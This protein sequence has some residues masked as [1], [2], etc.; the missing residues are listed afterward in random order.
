MVEYLLGHSSFEDMLAIVRTGLSDEHRLQNALKVLNI[1]GQLDQ[2]QITAKTDELDAARRMATSSYYRARLT[3]S[4][5]ELSALSNRLV[6]MQRFADP[7][8]AFLAYRAENAGSLPEPQTWRPGAAVPSFAG[9]Q[10][11]PYTGPTFEI[12]AEF[13]CPIS[14]ELMEDPVMTVDSFTYDRKN[15]ERW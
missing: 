15:I 14:G 4:Q 7:L 5:L 6:R 12:P 3:S 8:C 13:L 11:T 10:P 9:H 2:Q 1:L